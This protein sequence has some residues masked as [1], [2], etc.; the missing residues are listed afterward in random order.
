MDAIWI[1][2]GILLIAA[3]VLDL[4]MTVL[5]YDAAGPLSLR[6]Y[7]LT[8]GIC[9]R[10][11]SRVPPR[12][13]AFALSLGVP[14]MVLGSLILWIALQVLGFA[15][16]YYVG[17][18]GGAF[19]FSE[20]LE[21]SAVEALYLSGISLSG[22]GYG[23]LAPITAPFQLVAALQ[24]LMGYGFLTLAIAYVVNVYNVIED[25]GVLSSDIYHESE[26]TYEARHILEVH[27]HR[28]EP[29][30][31]NGRLINFY[32]GL[33]SHHEG[34]RHYPV[35]YYFY[36]RRG[37]AALPYRFG[38]IGRF[39]AALRWGLPEGE[40]VTEEPWLRALKSAYESISSEILERF[41]ETDNWQPSD[42]PVDKATFVSDLT[43][44]RSDD[45]LIHRFLELL[46]FMDELTERKQ[47]RV[48]D[49]VYRR[50]REWVPFVSRIDEFGETIIS[51]LS[52]R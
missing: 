6:L 35:V 26:R 41:L 12:H 29:R 40:P 36:S 39:V 43:Y 30:D 7:R 24:A 31:L 34:M 10:I 44:D 47:P 52:P 23:D 18:H 2:A 11:A 5:Y 33:I 14:L 20:G 3:G 21:A 4:F 1:V 13:T 48:P 17:L 38:L 42:I 19:R 22:L 27:F 8:W 32:N 45:A 37:Y 28:G 16:I 9:R 25:M 15:A 50:Y 46:D 51:H 49:E